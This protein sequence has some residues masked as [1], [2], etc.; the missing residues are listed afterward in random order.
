ML[1]KVKTRRKKRRANASNEHSQ[2]F[3]VLGLITKTI[4]FRQ[5]ADFQYIPPLDNPYLP[6]VN[7][8]QNSIFIDETVKDMINAI[9]NVD[10]ISIPPPVFSRVD[11]SNTTYKYRQKPIDPHPAARITSRKLK[12][13]ITYNPHLSNAIPT[14]PTQAIKDTIN[15]AIHSETLDK[16]KKHFDERPIYLSRA[17]FTGKF[18]RT[19]LPMVA[20]YTSKGP[21]RACW[22]RYGYDPR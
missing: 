17:L 13:S 3:Q 21:F 20:Y 4:R 14:A 22:V 9:N 1:I 10:P 15:Q 11:A 8:L 5:M 18:V 12:A 6:F 2:S 19:C 7:T 16:L